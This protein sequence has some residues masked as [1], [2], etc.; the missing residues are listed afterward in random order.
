MRIYAFKRKRCC[1]QNHGDTYLV[2]FTYTYMQITLHLGDF[3]GDK[4]VTFDFSDAC[5]FGQPVYFD[6]QD[7][8]KFCFRLF[9]P[10]F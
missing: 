5:L 4:N 1:V 2:R 10:M 6:Y 3:P 8:L 9:I 7:F